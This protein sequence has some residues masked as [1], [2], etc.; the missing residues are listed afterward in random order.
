MGVFREKKLRVLLRLV[1]IIVM[2]LFISL[3]I[4][5]AAGNQFFENRKNYPDTLAPSLRISSNSLKNLFLSPSFSLK[6]AANIKDE[7]GLPEN[8]RVDLFIKQ[9]LPV[10]AKIRGV[11][12]K[13][14]VMPPE[15]PR[16]AKDFRDVACLLNSGGT[17]L[18]NWRVLFPRTAVAWDPER[19]L[20]KSFIGIALH[21]DWN[22]QTGWSDTLSGKPAPMVGKIVHLNRKMLSSENKDLISQL[23][24]NK[25]LNILP[26]EYEAFLE[27]RD[28][29]DE[30]SAEYWRGYEMR[31]EKE[32][33]ANTVVALEDARVLERDGKVYV[34]LTVVFADGHYY[35]AVTTHDAE[36]MIANIKEQLED[37]QAEVE[38]EWTPLKKLITDGPCAEQNIKNFVPFGNPADD[39]KWYAIY[40][41]DGK[42]G[43]VVRLAV[44]E[45]GLDGKWKDAGEY[46]SFPNGSWGGGSTFVAELPGGLEMLLIHSARKVKGGETGREKDYDLWMLIVDR[47]NPHRNFFMGPILKAERGRPFEKDPRS[48]YPGAIYSCFATLAKSTPK[49]KGSYLLDIDIYYSAGDT[50]TS[51]ATV[52]VEVNIAGSTESHVASL[53]EDPTFPKA[54]KP[55][56]HENE[57]Q[58]QEAL[59]RLVKSDGHVDHEVL[60]E[61]SKLEGT[62]LVVSDNPLEYPGHITI[63]D[64]FKHRHF[65]IDRHG[66]LIERYLHDR[67]RFRQITLKNIDKHKEEIVLIADLHFQQRYWIYVDNE[68]IGFVDYTRL[69]IEIE[70]GMWDIRNIFL[71]EK[72]RDNGISKSVNSIF[73]KWAKEK[74]KA[75]A[76]LD[77]RFPFEA[78]ALIQ[79]LHNPT[80]P[81]GGLVTRLTSELIEDLPRDNGIFQNSIPFVIGIPN[82]FYLVSDGKGGFS[83]KQTEQVKDATAVIIKSDGSVAPVGI[84]GHAVNYLQVSIIEQA[85]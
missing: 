73:A 85:I 60:D 49:G 7:H 29:S 47:N 55:Q 35:S 52:T 21:L 40:R 24:E 11:K 42:G 43:S 69:P 19:E 84:N 59:K 54:V 48:W 33:E 4:A 1:A 12:W 38:W 37:P 57:V 17:T 2:E 81:S 27:E 10:Q 82:P 5:L 26:Q 31:L 77:V 8:E 65:V 9:L 28:F 80:I 18:N 66:I 50:A 15:A 6:S 67:H 13:G 72:Y 62:P 51:L 68:V 79:V 64:E 78:R 20:R 36:K 23:Q 61:I 14:V 63:K 83:V 25:K 3:D 22:E 44:S 45:T 56:E 30:Y 70:K 16:D 71:I 58:I 46:F 75:L 53:I 74:G 32:I 39:G 76:A 34:K 41:P